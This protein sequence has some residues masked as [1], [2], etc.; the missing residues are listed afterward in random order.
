[1]AQSFSPSSVSF[2]MRKE[3]NR[4]FDSTQAMDEACGA[5]LTD[6]DA[7]FLKVPAGMQ[8]RLKSS[9]LIDLIE[10]QGI[11]APRS[12][13]AIELMAEGDKRALWELIK[14]DWPCSTAGEAIKLFY[15]D[16]IAAILGIGA[17]D[18]V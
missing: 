17:Y 2:A 7:N 3:P 10:E 15:K 13:L 8:Y 5:M 14:W 12:P 16:K 4:H 11:P 1:M 18:G 6:L 9:L